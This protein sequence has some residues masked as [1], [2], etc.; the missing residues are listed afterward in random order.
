MCNSPRPQQ[1]R[2][3]ISPELA[4]AMAE[5]MRLVA[6]AHGIPDTQEITFTIHRPNPIENNGDDFFYAT[7]QVGG[8]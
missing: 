5:M 8:F 7:L 1:T 3:D 6:R 2:P 4:K